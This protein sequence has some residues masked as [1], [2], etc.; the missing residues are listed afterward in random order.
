MAAVAGERAVARLAVCMTV[1]P[2]RHQPG[3]R[4][5]VHDVTLGGRNSYV[6]GVVVGTR[7]QDDHEVYVVRVERRVDQG[8][9]MIEFPRE[10]LV[11]IDSPIDR[12]ERIPRST[13]H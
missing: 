4:V 12:I 8:E 10:R 9:E 2:W 6:D 1:P 7:R 13:R 5:R 11:L 3:D